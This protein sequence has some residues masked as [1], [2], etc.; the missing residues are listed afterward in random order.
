MKLSKIGI[1]ASVLVLI[2]SGVAIAAP[3]G[4]KVVSSNDIQEGSGFVCVRPLASWV[5]GRIVKRSTNL[6]QTLADYIKELTAKIKAT[7]SASQIAKLLKKRTNAKN[8]KKAGSEICKALPADSDSSP[9]PTAT[10]LPP[11]EKVFDSN[12][13]L[14]AT[15]KEKYGIPSNISTAN[16]TAGSSVHKAQCSGCHNEKGTGRSFTALRKDIE[17]SPMFITG[18]SDQNL[19]DLVAYLNRFDTR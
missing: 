16:L 15:G 9:L 6:I 2:C 5:P 3:R 17:S 12:G 18:I 4:A 19:A 13:N 1:Y 7:S 14:T 8:E 10:P 11:S